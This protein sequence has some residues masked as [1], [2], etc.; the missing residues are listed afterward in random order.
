MLVHTFNDY[1]AVLQNDGSLSGPQT[2][3]LRKTHSS[4]LRHQGMQTHDLL[5]QCTEIRKAARPIVVA[6]L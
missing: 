4:W 6:W 5:P 3:G 1:D 2:D